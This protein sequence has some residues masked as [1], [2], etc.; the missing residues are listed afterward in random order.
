MLSTSSIYDFSQE[1]EHY[2][3]EPGT[4]KRI[5]TLL[6]ALENHDKATP[7][8]LP[9]DTELYQIPDYYDIIKHPMDLSTCRRKYAK[10]RYKYVE[11]LLSDL[12]LIWKN[13]QTY[14]RENS[15]RLSRI[16]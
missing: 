14:N 8:K 15:V 4:K 9:V 1:M 11:E 12:A 5:E 16:S 3:D 6:S 10:R 13:C 2:V 7:F